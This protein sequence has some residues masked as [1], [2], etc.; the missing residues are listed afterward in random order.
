MSL[1]QMIKNL[2][3]EGCLKKYKS[4]VKIRMSERIEKEQEDLVR[5]R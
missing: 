2:K 4:M 3:G 1:R 5:K